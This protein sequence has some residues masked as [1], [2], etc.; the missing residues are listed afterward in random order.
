[1]WGGENATGALEAGWS[2]NPATGVRTVLAGDLQPAAR[3]LHTAVWTGSEMI[4]WGG[5]NGDSHP[6]DAASYDPQT[7]AW[8]TLPTDAAP[9]PRANHTAVWT[10]TEMI[11]WGGSGPDA[12]EAVVPLG[13][14]ARYV[15]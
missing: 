9:S 15:P 2:F 14:G 4:I 6:A 1:V 7:D 8:T 3:R 10:G 13:D 12:S 5:R 11:V